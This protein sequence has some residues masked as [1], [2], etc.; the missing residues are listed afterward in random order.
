MGVCNLKKFKFLKI[1]PQPELMLP[2]PWKP[3]LASF[4]SHASLSIP[5]L[6]WQWNLGTILTLS[7]ILHFCIFLNFN[8]FSVRGCGCV[9]VHSCGCW[10]LCQRTT[11]RSQFS[12]STVWAL[13]IELGP[14]DLEESACTLPPQA[15]SLVPC[16]KIYFYS[17]LCVRVC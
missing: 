9:C 7:F 13:D 14:L 4:W 16:F 5:S 6:L 1:S 17:H 12:P 10:C 3:L 11:L 15:I 8:L 2:V